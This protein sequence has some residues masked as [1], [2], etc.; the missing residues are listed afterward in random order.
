MSGETYIRT[1]ALLDTGSDATLVRPDIA[2][3]LK[4]DAVTQNLKIANAVLNITPLQSK[5]VYL[6]IYSNSQPD[7]YT[8]TY[9][10]VVPSL[11][12]KCQKHNPNSV[13][14]SYAHLRDIP[15]PRVI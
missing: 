11:S 4:L 13:K 15:I 7:P 8:M 2:N 5:L 1:I 12:V 6:E 10:W 9:A 3:C 14:L